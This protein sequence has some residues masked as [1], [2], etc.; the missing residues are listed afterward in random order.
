MFA[1]LLTISAL[2]FPT[3]LY[4]MDEAAELTK[5]IRVNLKVKTSSAP[6]LK[7]L[8]FEKCLQAAA[9]N[10]SLY[11]RFGALPKELRER[12]ELLYRKKHAVTLLKIFH[13][14]FKPKVIECLAPLYFTLSTCN[15]YLICLERENRELCLSRQDWESSRFL[16]V[17]QFIGNKIV[18][19][20][21]FPAIAAHITPD[22]KYILTKTNRTTELYSL[23][24]FRL[25]SCFPKTFDDCDGII[26]DQTGQMFLI[27]GLWSIQNK[28]RDVDAPSLSEQEKVLID[29]F[30]TLLAKI[31]KEASHNNIWYIYKS[32]I[33]RT[34][35]SAT[36]WLLFPQSSSL[37]TECMIRN[38][39]P[40]NL[41]TQSTNI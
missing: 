34:W 32:G 29:H 11:E 40:L 2:F 8:A 22:S 27:E 19:L 3:A 33:E 4:P 28:A 12:V 35:V 36:D 17:F 9:S 24:D 23:P 16:R 10:S 37:R 6:T 15:E 25:V 18:E 38:S 14:S 13:N 20:T 41:A 7:Q 1:V 26:F 21:R 30:D 31:K 39:I 5:V